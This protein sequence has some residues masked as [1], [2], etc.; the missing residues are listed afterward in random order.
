MRQRVCW[1]PTALFPGVWWGALPRCARADVGYIAAQLLSSQPRAG[2][3]LL[4][5]LMARAEQLRSSSGG[6]S[7]S[8]QEGGAAQLDGVLG[9]LAALV[10]ADPQGS[11][12]PAVLLYSK[13]S[14]Q[15]S[16][17][18]TVLLHLSW[19][20]LG[21]CMFALSCIFLYPATAMQEALPCCPQELALLL[22]TPRTTTRRLLLDIASSLLQYCG[23]QAQQPTAV[24]AHASLL[25]SLLTHA[26]R[27]KDAGLRSK[28]V[29][30]L[31]KN[32]GV[33]AGW[34]QSGGGGEQHAA[35]VAEALAA[36]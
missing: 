17:H 33:L 23:G 20:V 18:C 16:V 31:E 7:G 15:A 9:V 27:D 21:D 11:A 10:A 30:A 3:S 19:H 24:A 2:A 22:H 8:G 25:L 34:G 26:M 35:L 32:A 14:D 5:H 13:V 36:R 12:A 6:S 1:L 29:A 28:A 4:A